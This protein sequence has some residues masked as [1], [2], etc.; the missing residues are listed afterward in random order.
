MRIRQDDLNLTNNLQ[1]DNF[2]GLGYHVYDAQDCAT[3]QGLKRIVLEEVSP[4]EP[5]DFDLLCLDE[6][7]DAT[8]IIYAFIRKLIRDNQSKKNLQY[9]V[10]GD[11]R[12][13]IYAFNH[14]DKRFLT[15]AKNA[16]PSTRRWTSIEHRTSYRATTQL[17]KFYNK[18]LLNPTDIPL[19]AVKNGVPPRYLLCNSYSDAI[20][21]ELLR[22]LDFLDPSQILVL[23]PSIRSARSPVRD[24]ANKI[25]LTYPSISCYIPTSDEETLSPTLLE[26]KLLFCTYHQA[27][28]IERE[29]VLMFCFDTSYYKLYSRGGDQT[30][31]TNA[32]YVGAT[33]SSRHLTVI[34]DSSYDYLPFLDRDTLSEHCDILVDREPIPG[35]VEEPEEKKRL[36]G[37][38]VT[39]LTRHV[40]EAV[41]S[42]CFE[43]F[44]I[45]LLE[46]PPAKYRVYPPTTVLLDNGLP[47][48]VADITGTAIPAIYEYRSRGTCTLL[49]NVQKELLSL[50]L[51]PDLDPGEG[52]IEH[53]FEH[54]PTHLREKLLD[55]TPSTMT[56]SDFLLVANA[57]NTSL[58]GY[59][60]KLLQIK[61]YN[62]LEEKHVKPAM[63][64]LQKHISRYAIYERPVRGRVVDTDVRGR[65]DVIDGNILWELKWTDSIRPEHVLQLVSY[66]ALD[67]PKHP[68]RVYK[69]LHVP[70]RQIVVVKPL[71]GFRGVLEEL[72]KVRGENNRS[73]G[74]TDDAFLG[75]L[76]NEF[77][78]FVGGLSIPPWLN[79]RMAQSGR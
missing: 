68:K 19:N 17:V 37:Y 31:I 76:G 16:F 56:L 51:D 10:L 61:E 72:V 28:G 35:L 57:A 70:T 18:Q 38:A 66:A 32:Q 79:T 22:Y 55:L 41:S 23:A 8:P 11:P 65:V 33:R 6:L 39:D 25:A 58:S 21:E 67:S 3:D 64:V 13:E 46:R 15:M 73:L 60:H 24:L 30:T 5:L 4:V 7:Q 29:A 53:P 77:A 2:H 14:A 27:K 63:T 34:H 26:G 49:E 40:P 36:P 43:G 69:L 20:L 12:Q 48:T 59:I 78:G 1:V 75:E 62:W 52:A 54:L 42:Y 74:L 44:F 45:P 47:E 50:K 71:R 9:L